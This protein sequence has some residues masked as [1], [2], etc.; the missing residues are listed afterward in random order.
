MFVIAL[1]YFFGGVAKL[2][3]NWLNSNLVSKIIS[4]SKSSLLTQIFSNDILVPFVKYGG[5]I[6]DLSVVFLLLYRR[7][8][9]IGVV[10]VIVFNYTNNTLLFDDIGIFPFFMICSI[11]LFFD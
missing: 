10:L 11:V 4:N 7:T 3:G 6:Y 1:P 2:S 5:L 9:I 8:R